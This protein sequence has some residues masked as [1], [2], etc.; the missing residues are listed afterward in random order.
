MFL[1][2][3]LRILRQLQQE[4]PTEYKAKLF[5]RVESV[6]LEG[7]KELELFIETP[8]GRSRIEAIHHL[9]GDNHRVYMIFAEFLTRDSLD[10]LM[11]P[12][13]QTLDELT[14]YYQAR[15]AWLSPQQRKILDA[16]NKP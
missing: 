2:L 5:D 10:K 6:Y 11:K 1:D 8:K 9:A 16:M 15:I 14:P 4:Y 7:N 3:L 12:F 13:L